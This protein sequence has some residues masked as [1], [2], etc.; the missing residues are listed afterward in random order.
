MIG[1]IA[2]SPTEYTA[3]VPDPKADAD[4]TAEFQAKLDPAAFTDPTLKP[5][6][7]APAD[8]ETW[9]RTPVVA[10][11]VFSDSPISRSL[12]RAAG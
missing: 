1:R 12:L 5:G 3:G 6:R 8:P 4:C 7:L 9:A 10:C 11:V 2:Y